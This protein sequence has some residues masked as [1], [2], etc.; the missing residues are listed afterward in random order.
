MLLIVQKRIFLFI[1]FSEINDTSNSDYIPEVQ[2]EIVE[3]EVRRSQR[4]PKTKV[5]TDHVT[6]QC[7]KSF[8][9]NSVTV[10]VPEA[11]TT[12]NRAKW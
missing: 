6:Y 12:V 8:N 2:V 3:T 1:I 7:T 11:M 5:F 4:Q 10:T 9:L